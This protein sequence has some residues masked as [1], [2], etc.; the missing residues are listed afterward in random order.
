[1]SGYLTKHL[2][3]ALV[4]SQL[5]YCSVICSHTAENNLERMQEAQYNAAVA[6]LFT[7]HIKQE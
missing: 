4:L 7:A 2:V 5:D 6:L 3:Q 1:M